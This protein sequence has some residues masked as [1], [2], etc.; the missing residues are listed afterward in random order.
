M[1]ILLLIELLRCVLLFWFFG[2]PVAMTF[3]FL[4][5]V[6]RISSM[7][8][9][10]SGVI[11]VGTSNLSDDIHELICRLWAYFLQWLYEPSQATLALGTT[12]MRSMLRGSLCWIARTIKQLLNLGPL[13][14]LHA[15]QYAMMLGVQE[16]AKRYAF[17]LVQ[18]TSSDCFS[19]AWIYNPFLM[20]LFIQDLFIKRTRHISD[21]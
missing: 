6:E 2:C 11:S 10:C 16:C 15:L 1:N 17:L 13:L 5:L 20:C 18:I 4:R 7:I 3:W 8:L 21:H 9:K 14:L 19:F 12:A